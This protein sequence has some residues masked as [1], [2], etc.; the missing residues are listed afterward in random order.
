MYAV[1]AAVELVVGHGGWLDRSD[2]VDSFVE[3]ALSLSEGTPMAWIDWPAAVVALEAGRLPC[4][5]SEAVLL[6]AAA[7]LAE[8]APVDLRDLVSVLD[9]TNLVLLTGALLHAG[10]MADAVVGV[11]GRW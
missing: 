11:D 9:A 5:G 6:R 1:E 2:F 7:S 10:G 4:S 8:G 3:T